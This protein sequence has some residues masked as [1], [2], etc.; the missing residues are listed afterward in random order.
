MAACA[1]WR[2]H[3]NHFC[4]VRLL[5]CLQF[6]TVVFRLWFCVLFLLVDWLQFSLLITLFPLG[7][8]P[9]VYPLFLLASSSALPGWQGGCLHFRKTNQTSW[10]LATS[11]LWSLS[12]F[13][14][15][16]FHCACGSGFLRAGCFRPHKPYFYRPASWI[17]KTCR[18]DFILRAILA[19]WLRVWPAGS[20]NLAGS[21][22]FSASRIYREDPAGL[23]SQAALPLSRR[24]KPWYM[25]THL[26]HFK[27]G[28]HWIFDPVLFCGSGF[29][30]FCSGW[31]PIAFWPP[32]CPGWTAGLTYG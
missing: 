17:G 31:L 30:A 32:A 5:Y 28:H 12:L 21:A 25:R 2:N 1:F 16:S 9:P 6:L 27:P 18:I 10:Q 15:N 8:R 19:D 24:P 13:R 7:L 20:L 23:A 22:G 26:R 29:P 3:F 11:W 4:L 14:H